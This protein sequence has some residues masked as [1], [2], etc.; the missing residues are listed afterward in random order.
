MRPGIDDDKQVLH[1]LCDL[2]RENLVYTLPGK[3]QDILIHTIKDMVAYMQTHWKCPIQNLFVDG[4]RGL[5]NEFVNW[6]KGKGITVYQIPFYTKEPNG[7]IERSGRTLIARA[8]ALKADS[9]LP[10]HL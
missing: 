10:D 2:M 5:G 6:A 3:T 4:E 1:G 8:R 9:K 7:N